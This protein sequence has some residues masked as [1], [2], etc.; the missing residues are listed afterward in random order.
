MEQLLLLAQLVLPVLLVRLL[1]LLPL[2][3]Q[4]HVSGPLLMA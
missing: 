2:Q 1:L 3:L 4:P